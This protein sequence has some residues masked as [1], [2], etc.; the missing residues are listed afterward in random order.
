M[1]GGGLENPT[2]SIQGPVPPYGHSWLWFGL[3]FTPRPLR[4]AAAGVEGRQGEAEYAVAPMPVPE[5]SCSPH[6]HPPRARAGGLAAAV[7]RGRSDP[8]ASLPTPSPYQYL[9]L[10]LVALEPL[11][12]LAPSPLALVVAA[13][14]V[15]EATSAG[16]RACGGALPR[17]PAAD[18]LLVFLIPPLSLL[19]PF[20]HSSCFQIPHA[21]PWHRNS[22]PPHL[23]L[24]AD[25]Y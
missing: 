11:P 18:V 10:S 13:A 12:P 1:M 2:V 8:G 7:R 15:K 21:L 9:F 5:L 20:L 24:P 23:Q 14:P 4:P 3:E 25:A 19:L 17:V 6:R 16:A 22:S